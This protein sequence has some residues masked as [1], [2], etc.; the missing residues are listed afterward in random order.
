MNIDPGF[1]RDLKMYKGLNIIQSLTSDLGDGRT[2]H[3]K[4]LSLVF[5]GPW[6]EYGLALPRNKASLLS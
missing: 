2:L 1:W 6:E 4:F 3:L 5:P